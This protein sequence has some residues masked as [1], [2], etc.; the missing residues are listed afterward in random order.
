MDSNTTHGDLISDGG[1]TCGWILTRLTVILYQTEALPVGGFWHYSR[2][3]YIRRRRYLW[4]DS[5]TTHS[6]LISDGGAT[7]GWILTLLTVILYQTEAL[8]VGGFWHDSRWSYIRRRRYLWVDSNTTHG[9][10]ISD[11][12]ATCGWILT[13]LTVILYQTEALPV[14]GF[15]HDSQWSYIRRRRYLWVDSD[16]THSDLIS[17]GGATCG[18]ILTLLTVI[19]YQTEALPVGGFWHDSRWS[20]IRRR[21]YL[22]VDSDTTHS[23]LISDGGATCGWI[24][25]LLTVILYQTEALPVG[26][27]WHYSRWSYIRRRRYLWVDS[28]TTH[29]DLISDGGAT[30]GWILTLLTVILYQTEALPVGGFWHDSRWSY[31]RRRRYLWVDS[32]T[33]H[34][35]LISDG[36]ATCGWILTLHT[37]ILYQTEALPVGGSLLTVI[38][39][40]TEA[41]PVGGF[42]HYSQWSYIRRRRYLWVDSDTTH[43]DLISDGGATCGW[44]LTLLTVILYQTEALPVGGFWHYSQW[45]YIRRRR[46]LWVDSDTTHGDLISDGGATCGWI[47]TLHTVILYQTEALPVD[48]F[49]HYSRWSYIRRRRYL[50]VDSDTTHGDLISDGG[51]TCGWILTL[52]TVIL[53]QTEALPVDGFWHYTQ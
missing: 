1:A 17:D 40:Q 24:L 7:C 42:W 4:V 43:S 14:G 11:G 9:D 45:S 51:A 35:D 39:Y 49:W 47:L 15:W 19:L 34:S 6:D 23:D 16:T 2:W 28:D 27:F 46:Y 36:G 25:T 12:G 21:R 5:D 52:L 29:S 38:L 13:L 37:V 50:W 20:Y 18:W 53:Y 3:S 31:I 48:G 8:P 44:I 33:T 10:L 26:G 22:W 30:C 32:D 41:L